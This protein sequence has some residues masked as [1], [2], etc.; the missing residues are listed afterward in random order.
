VNIACEGV[1]NTYITLYFDT[2]RYTQKLTLTVDV[3]LDCTKHI[4]HI[5]VQIEIHQTTAG[6]VFDS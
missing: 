5:S 2:S 4:K 6:F 3:Q 1:K